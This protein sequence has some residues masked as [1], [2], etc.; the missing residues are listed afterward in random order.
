MGVERFHFDPD[1]VDAFVDC[2][3][4]FQGLAQK[5]SDN[6]PDPP[7]SEQPQDEVLTVAFSGNR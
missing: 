1:V 7:S 5:L 3:Q 2:V 4:Q 6:G